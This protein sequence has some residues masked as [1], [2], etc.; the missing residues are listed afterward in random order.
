MGKAVVHS[1]LPRL[2]VKQRVAAKARPTQKRTTGLSTLDV[3][4]PGQ[5]MPHVRYLGLQAGIGLVP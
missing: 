5:A 4:E 2:R 1:A 3:G